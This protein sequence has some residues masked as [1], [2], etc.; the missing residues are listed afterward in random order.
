MSIREFIEIE[1][2]TYYG[3]VDYGISM[4]QSDNLPEARYACVF[5][6]VCINGSW[7]IPTAY[8]L[9]RSLSGAERANIIKI[10]LSSLHE[11]GAN[12]VNITMDG[13]ASNIATMQCLGANISADN[14]RPFF[15]HPQTREKVYV[16]LDACHMIKLIRNGFT[17]CKNLI[18]EIE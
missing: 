11:I 6:I 15:M 4:E 13:C 17:T 2:D 16:L 1:N 10:V 18:M 14:P 9:I 12:I 5:L 3:Y 8:Y 7:K